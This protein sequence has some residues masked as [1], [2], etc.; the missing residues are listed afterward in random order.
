VDKRKILCGA[1]FGGMLMCFGDSAGM[2]SDAPKFI[3][4]YQAPGQVNHNPAP[5]NYKP[6][7]FIM[8]GN[9]TKINWGKWWYIPVGQTRYRIKGET[10]YL[11]VKRSDVPGYLGCGRV[12][13]RLL[14]KHALFR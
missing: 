12:I 6:K 2:R 1:L 7:V 4:G 5:Q 10:A 14:S 9:V 11:V 3:P 13:N 8:L